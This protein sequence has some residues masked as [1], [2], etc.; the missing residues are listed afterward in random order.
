MDVAPV[1]ASRRIPATPQA[2]FAIL[3]DPGW[4]TEIDGSGMLRGAIDPVPVSGVGEVFAMRMHH[5][6][7][8]D[9]EMNNTVVEFE[10]DRVITWEPSRRDIDVEHWHYRW[11]Y[12]LEPAGDGATLVTESFDLS[13]S[14]E[15]AREA[16][17]DG[18]VWMEAMAASLEH[19]EHLC[20]AGR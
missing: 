20:T 19:L 13:H 2:I 10:T 9:Y 16:T 12:E 18:A 1:S 4:H 5:D 3:V 17:Q 14:P 8:G 7:M 11:R 15:E 6:D